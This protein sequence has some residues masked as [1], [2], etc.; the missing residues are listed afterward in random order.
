MKC[1]VCEAVIPLRDR[2]ARLSEATDA[3]QTSHYMHFDRQGNGGRTCPACISDSAMRTALH[4]ELPALLA[5]VAALERV[6]EAARD[7]QRYE[8]EYAGLANAI[9]A[10]DALRAEKKP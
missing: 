7:Y 2:L 6:A 1:D 9:A 8:E 10:L 4:N 3:W 5:E